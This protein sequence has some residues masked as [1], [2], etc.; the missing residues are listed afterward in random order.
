MV[1]YYIIFVFLGMSQE[2]GTLYNSKLS[3]E[4]MDECGEITWEIFRFF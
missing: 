1:Y 2:I 4:Q 3:E